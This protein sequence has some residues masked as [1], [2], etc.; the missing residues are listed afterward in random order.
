M[1]LPWGLDRLKH[2]LRRAL[3]GKRSWV[4]GTALLLG[5]VIFPLV[6]P[7]YYVA[8]G[9]ALL[10]NVAIASSWALFSGLTRYLSLASAA[11]Y[12]A[13]AYTT[14]VLLAKLAWPL[15]I[16]AGAVVAALLALG[17][18]LLSL[19]LRGPYFAI[20]TFG[21][22]ELV[23]HMVVWYESR[24]TGTVGR[25]LLAQPDRRT[26]YYGLLVIAVAAVSVAIL[27][28]RSRLGLM[29]LA[30]GGDEERTEVLGVRPT[31]IKVGVFVLSAMLMGATGA[32]IAPR[33]TYIDPQIAF[34]P[35]ISFQAVIMAL[36]GGTRR[37]AGPV[38]GALF[39]GVISELFLLQFRYV[40]MMIL[41]AVLILTVLALPHG[42]TGWYLEERTRDLIRPVRWA[43]ARRIPR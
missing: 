30:I 12:G 37:P 27:L 32:A 43:I 1:R 19:R 16:L 20:L 26:I 2:R 6:G 38:I 29:L 8:F 34:N 4:W 42:I 15:P 23:R 35:L 17:V 7:A 14:A 39:L 5:L 22:S 10:A 18:G 24:F 28:Y 11:F 13:G 41:G 36:L 33:W 25:I 21:L 9:L 31:W 40:Y 3:R